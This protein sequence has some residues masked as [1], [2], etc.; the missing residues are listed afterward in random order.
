MAGS[1]ERI[2][3]A[4]RDRSPGWMA[5]QLVRAFDRE[6][7]APPLARRLTEYV[8][9]R[10]CGGCGQHFHAGVLERVTLGGGVWFLCSGCA[11][12]ARS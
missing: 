11:S 6:R 5:R 2:A 4:H 12:L 8:G 9:P 3:H 10:M 7:E 1:A